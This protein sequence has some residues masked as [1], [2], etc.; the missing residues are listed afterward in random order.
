MVMVANAKEIRCCI[1]TKADGEKK[2]SWA[3]AWG[4]VC[5]DFQQYM[6]NMWSIAALIY[7]Y[8]FGEK[9]LLSVINNSVSK[10]I[11]GRVEFQIFKLLLLGPTMS[12][13]P[14]LGLQGMLGN[15]IYYNGS[16]ARWQMKRNSFKSF[17]CTYCFLQHAQASHVRG[18]L[19][20]FTV[21]S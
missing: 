1:N 16:G 7:M 8:I 9:K 20:L 10:P 14:L 15:Q 18:I 17:Y 19:N 6:W 2:R 5:G 21:P 3:N 13:K 11:K 4:C 12:C